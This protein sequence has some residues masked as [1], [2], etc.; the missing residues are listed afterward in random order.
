MRHTLAI[1]LF[2]ALITTFAYAQTVGLVLSGG[3]ASGL[4]HI[5]VLKALE[6]NSIPIDYIT[7]SSIGAFI[8]GLYAAGYSPD[9]I[10]RI[11]TSD[12]FKRIALGQIEDRYLYYFRKPKPNASWISLRLSL[13]ST[14]LQTSIP[15]SFINPAPLDMELMYLLE[16]AALASEYNFDSLFIPFRCIASDIEDKESVLFQSGNLNT[17][18]R[19]SMSYPLYLE[20]LRVNGKLLF[21]GGLYNNFPTDIM[22]DEFNPEVIIGSNV[23]ANEEPPREGDAISQLRNM[24]VSKTNYELGSECCV[25]IEPKVEYGTFDFKHPTESVDS[26][27]VE[28]MRHIEEIKAKVHRRVHEKVISNKRKNFNKKK[29]PLQFEKIEFTGLTKPQ[30]SYVGLAIK[31]R[32]DKVLSMDRLRKGYFKLY[33][34]EKI[35]RIF[36]TTHGLTADS[37][38]ILKLDV[39]KEKDLLVELGGNVASRPI[40]GG[41]IGLGYGGI[42]KFGGASFYANSHFGRFYNSLLGTGRLDLP[43]RLPMYLQLQGVFNKW[44]YQNSRTDY[45]VTEN[46]SYLIQTDRFF[47]GDA[48]FGLSNKSKFMIGGGGLSLLDRY[49]QTQEIGDDDLA[50]VTLFNGSTFSASFEQNSLNNKLY[51]N[52]GSMIMFS[53]RYSTG[54]EIYNPG[55]TSIDPNRKVKLHDWFDLKFAYDHY[56]VSKGFL[57]LGLYAE[58]VYSTL[59]LFSNYASSTLREP[60]F[61][62]TPESKTLFLESFRAYQFAAVGHKFILNIYRGLDLRL[63]GYVFQPYRYVDRYKAETDLNNNGN[64]EDD[65]AFRERRN[66]DFRY[67]LATANAVYKSPLGPI[68]FSVNYYYNV[69]EVS[70][71]PNVNPRTPVTFLFHFGYILFNDKAMQ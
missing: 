43:I 45:L 10:E 4:A 53:A 20:P 15:T 25:L 48:A 59:S 16:P 52:A 8:G 54:E 2:L 65:F 37:N 21:D 13:D 62:P 33:E 11:V 47:R 26:G 9:E 64:L 31:P 23:S 5:G 17:A 55:P 41:Y 7:G 18:V 56:Y 61:Q 71:D 28:T 3:G 36:P 63:E 35:K 24:V 44:N 1:T 39:K 66:F 22:R 6:E 51:P 69:P 30:R 58:G 70:G 68:S 29:I 27:Y 60:S 32:K 40:G 19:A 42:S 49:Y 14:I 57:R 46:S 38:Y 67:I 34:S 50:D 12:Y